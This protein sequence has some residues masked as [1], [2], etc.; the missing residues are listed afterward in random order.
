MATT[1]QAVAVQDTN[2][3]ILSLLLSLSPLWFIV[4]SRT[5]LGLDTLHVGLFQVVLLL[6]LR[7]GLDLIP[8]RLRR[9]TASPAPAPVVQPAVQEEAR[10]GNGV[11]VKEKQKS[12][13]RVKR[14]VAAAPPAPFAA[15]K[16]D[17]TVANFLH[18]TEPAF[19]SYVPIKPTTSIS[20]APLSDWKKTFSG[21]NV[22]VLQHPTLSSLFGI[23]ATFPDVPIRNL[24]Q[25]LQDI[26]K[27]PVWDGMCSGA[28][29]IERF[30]VDGRKGNA[31][32]MQMKGM[33]MIKAK[34]L[35][36]LSVA[37]KL[38]TPED[39]MEDGQPT[40][41]KLRIFAASTSVDHP[42]V[43]PTPQYNRMTLS[44]SGF[45]IEEVGKG[46]KI[47]Q[48]TDL[49]G[50]GSWVPNSV[51]RTITQ[52]MLPKSLAKLGAAAADVTEFTSDFPPPTLGKKAP[53]TANGH[54]NGEA[55]GEEAEE[56]EEEESDYEDESDDEDSSA[57]DATRLSPSASRDLHSL[58]SQLR[59]LTSRLAALETLVSS[60]SAPASSSGVAATP[61]RR[62]Y[63]PFSSSS[64]SGAG[65]GYGG[66]SDMMTMSPG[67][68][69]AL[70]TLGSAAGAAIAVAAV[71]AVARR[72]K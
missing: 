23:C 22:E 45:F 56:E 17:E 42:K 53:P 59:S 34:D 30:E 70:A 19:L 21:D 5:R 27:R 7:A 57:P 11:D 43:P 25:V 37:G 41:E 71:T 69:S 66:P 62:W 36:L 51:L 6:V 65:K 16:L 61:T 68:L 1:Q 9:K 63:S 29:E 32:T 33:A 35:V 48:I 64:G 60:P 18:I 49:S 28:S 67:K 39:D 58:L 54:A 20:S 8:T 31:L 12:R 47:V 55:G 50:L 13:R 14:K 46:S 26:G 15:E 72:R 24:F 52:T 4:Q 40:A 2:K 3:S 38:P 10:V 44:I